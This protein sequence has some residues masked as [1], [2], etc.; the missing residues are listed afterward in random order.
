MTITRGKV[1]KFLGITIDY[2]SSGKLIF[3]VIYYIGKMLYDIPEDMKG[4]SSTPAA[5][6]LFAIAEDSTKLS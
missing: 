5:H 2:S 1:K 3:S 4:E 6:N